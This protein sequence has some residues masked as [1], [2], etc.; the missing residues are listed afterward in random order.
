MASFIVN[1]GVTDTIPKTVSNNDIGTLEAG[2]TLTAATAIT[3]TGGSNAPGVVIDNSGSVNGAHP[4]DRQLRRIRRRRQ[5]HRQQQRRRYHFRHG[6]RRMARQQRPQRR[7][8]HHAEQ[9][10]H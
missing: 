3:W 1:S 4:R 8:H 9:R 7:R 10:R 5:H 6:Q 2:G